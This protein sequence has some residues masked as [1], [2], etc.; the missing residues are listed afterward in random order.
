MLTGLSSP[1]LRTLLSFARH[2]LTLSLPRPPSHHRP[3]LL[4]APPSG[5]APLSL[6]TSLLLRAASFSL[7]PPSSALPLLAPVPLSLPVPVSW[8]VP[9]LVRAPWSPLLPPSA[10]APSLSLALLLALVPRFPRAP[11]SAPASSGLAAPHRRSATSRLAN[12]RLLL[13]TPLPSRDSHPSTQRRPPKM[14]SR[15]SPSAATTRTVSSSLTRTSRRLTTRSPTSTSPPTPTSTR[16]VVALFLT[17]RLRPSERRGAADDRRRTE[18]S[19]D[20]HEF[21][22]SWIHS[23]INERRQG[24]LRWPPGKLDSLCFA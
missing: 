10:K 12:S 11:L 13:R 8:T 19:G 7:A 1:L 15:S 4:M 3:R 9:R 16:S 24:R 20:I 18:M 6:V 14:C 2:S 23:G 21:M 5:T 17:A 22:N